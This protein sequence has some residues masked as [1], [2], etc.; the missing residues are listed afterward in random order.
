MLANASRICEAKFGNM[1]LYRRRNVPRCGG[2][3]LVRVDRVPVA[4]SQKFG[5]ARSTRLAGWPQ[6]DKC[7]ISPM[8]DWNRSI[9]MD[10]RR[11]LNSL[12]WRGHVRCC[13]FPCAG[14]HNWSASSPFIDKRSVPFTDKQ[15]E[16]VQNFAAQAVIAI[17][18]TRLLNE[19]RQR[20][21]D[22]SEVAGTADRDKRGAQ[23]HLQLAGRPAA[24]VSS[25]AG[26]RHSY[27]SRRSS[28]ICSA[29]R[30]QH[31]SGS[32]H[33]TVPLRMGGAA[34]A[35]S[36]GFAA[37]KQPACPRRQNKAAATRYRF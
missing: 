2:S 16:L 28:E 20:T 34:T 13:L 37:S 32:G 22:L 4:V 25:H 26:E 19:L 33:C 31:V 29:L 6:R 12:T 35:Q 18:N 11:W 3:R 9:A 24:G 7:S 10:L 27:L 30:R 8:C 36:S 17:E 23:G 5:R 1:L 14:R 15:I 21:D